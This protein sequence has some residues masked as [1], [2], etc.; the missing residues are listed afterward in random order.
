MRIS[1]TSDRW[2][3]NAVIYCLD[4]ERY[5]DSNDD[6]CGDMRGL[7]QRID[8]LAELGITCL[9]LMPLNSS[10]GRDDGYD[11]TDF[12]AID[13]R[14]GNFGEFVEVIRTARDRGI[15]VVMDLVINHTSDQHPWFLDS[16]SSTES[17][18]RDFYVW[19]D[20]PPTKDQPSAFPNDAKSIWEFD[21]KTKQYYLH[22]F[23]KHQPDLNIAHPPVRDEIARI[24]GFW[25][26]LG[27]SGFRV[28]AVPFLIEAK[29]E[30]GGED[31]DADASDEPL[32]D[33]HD[34]LADISGFL[35]RRN[36]EAMLLGEVNLSHKEQLA[37]FGAGER[38]ELQM[39]FDFVV[40]QSIYLSMVREDCRPL[41]TALAD[42]P[43]LPADCQW[44]NFVRNHDELTLDKLGDA[45]R[46]EV[47]DAFAPDPD[48]R[49][50]DRGIRRRLPTML[51]G[52]A[53]R[54]RM[55]YSLMFS[56]PGAPVLFYGEEI[57]MGEN[58]AVK[59]RYAV[60]TPMQWTD[61]PNAGFSRAPADQLV[62]PVVTGAFGPEWVNAAAQ[63]RDPDSLAH[64]M[65]TLIQA[66]RNSPEIGWGDL[67]ILKHGD[68]RVFAH[69]VRADIGSM[70]AVHNFA[71]APVEL[72]LTLPDVAPGSRLVDMLHNGV[73]AID[74][75]EVTLRLDP[76]GYRWLR[77]TSDA[78]TRLG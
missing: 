67:T 39:Q 27:V 33:P 14:L 31:S 8:Y 48:M 21:K 69:L 4:V 19:R 13:S 58:L 41:A 23:Y 34:Y 24:V 57:G 61:G 22:N 46:Q 40:M 35:A 37:Y 51:G 59:D 65:R 49:L 64:F 36:S 66:Y 68:D 78:D 47:F 74:D 29:S 26:E 72:A 2:W 12:Y 50:Y 20:D 11:I 53:R 42:R 62:T 63:R 3:K 17:K 15:R 25:T 52:D 1:D 56:L 6:G 60:R 9:W 55:A 73:T 70:L 10:P 18:Y 45:E 38:R 16:R 28:D 32:P 76:Y 71:N 43:E 54:I 77:I 44:G 7:A 75:G 30:A 5:L